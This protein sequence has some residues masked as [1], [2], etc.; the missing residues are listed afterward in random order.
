MKHFRS[1]SFIK[2]DDYEAFLPAKLHRKYQWDQWEL[3]SA[4]EE[5]TY[6]LGEL[7][8]FSQLIPN[9]E[10][11]IKL[12]V[13]KEA[14]DSSKIEGTQTNMEQAFLTVEE[15]DPEQKDDWKELDNYIQAMNYCM[16]R[17]DTLPLSSRLLKEAHKILMDGVR[18]DYKMPGQFRKSQNWIGGSSL[19][20]A[21]F[22]PPQCHEI[23]ELMGDLENFMHDS[24]SGLPH[25][26]KIGL[27]HYQFE[28][29][30]PF[31]DGN[32]RIGRL[33]ISL[34][35]MQWGLLK[36]PVLYLSDYFDRHRFRY[37]DT[38]MG[39]R[40]KNDLHGWLEFFVRGI[41]DTCHKSVNGLT[42][43]IALRTECE[44]ERLPQLGRKYQTALQ[45][46]QYLFSQPL[47]R[48][49]K[50]AEFTGLSMVSSYKLIEDFEK[51]GILKETTGG[52]RYRMYIFEEYFNIFR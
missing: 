13:I 23:N 33:M 16:E 31:L 5:A 18:G 47:V 42:S 14:S 41:S 25:V 10:H 22:V 46:L 38:L 1:G 50:V 34:Y 17:L 37:Y 24:H 26:V 15:V 21:M 20:D 12:H 6:L 4:V 40:M 29:I 39:V 52:L 30:H 51:L 44:K 11:F 19:K 7:N 49:D 36:K 8:A 32:G 28:T 45:L 9:V 48:A 2:A 3:H 27:A 35:L 43:I